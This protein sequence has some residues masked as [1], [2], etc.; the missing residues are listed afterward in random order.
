MK[1]TTFNDDFLY[2]TIDEILTIE[3]N[4]VLYEMCI[5]FHKKYKN[6]IEDLSFFILEK[7]LNLHGFEYCKKNYLIRQNNNVKIS[8]EELDTFNSITRNIENRLNNTELTNYY[9]NV[10]EKYHWHFNL[11]I[12]SNIPL[13]PHT[14]NPIDLIEYGIKNNV[15]VS[16][17]IYKGVIYIG[18]KNVKYENYGTRMYKTNEQNSEIVE[19]PFIPR[20]ACV[21]KTGHNS[22]HGTDFKDDL[23]YDRYSITIQYYED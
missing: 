17:G 18:D 13:N 15:M 1:I 8:N 3:E 12:S 7:D 22:W 5:N 2:S 4:S 14:D 10:S 23:P 19:I 6:Q 16:C 20:N 11:V 9:P 21:F